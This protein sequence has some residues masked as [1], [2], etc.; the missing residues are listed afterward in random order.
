MAFMKL[1]FPAAI[2]KIKAMRDQEEKDDHS[3]FTLQELTNF[4]LSQM[5]YEDAMEFLENSLH[6]RQLQK[7]GE[8][9]EFSGDLSK[10]RKMIKFK[11]THEAFRKLQESYVEAQMHLSQAIEE[12]G[13]R[14]K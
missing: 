2:E 7:W 10:E 8:D 9:N 3:H 5:E 14:L 13:K 6:H 12:G 11:P 4:Y 1:K